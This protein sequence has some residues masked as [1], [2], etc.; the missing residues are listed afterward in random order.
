MWHKIIIIVSEFF[1]W[2]FF[3]ITFFGKLKYADLAIDMLK[4]NPGLAKVRNK[5]DETGLTVLARTPLTF[6]GNDES[7]SAGLLK[8]FLNLSCKSTFNSI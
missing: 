6:V 1:L 4:S 2:Y 7:Q 3:S 8:S 5:Y